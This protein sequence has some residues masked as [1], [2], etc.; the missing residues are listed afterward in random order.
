[1][2]DEIGVEVLCAAMGTPYEI[3]GAMHLQKPAVMR[4]WHSGVRGLAGSVTA[5]RL[6]G[7]PASIAARVEKLKHNLRAYGDIHVFDTEA[8]L[9]FWAE[10]RQLT[11]FYGSSAALWRISTT[12]TL[13]PKVVA[14]IERYMKVEAFYDWSG[15]LIW[16]EVPEAADAGATDIRR[17]I[18]LHGGHATLIRAEPS[19]RA[20]V[21][22]FQP[23]EP[24][25]ARITAKLKET[26]DPAGVFNPGRMYA[27]L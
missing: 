20:A 16:L 11:V 17:I 14:G 9:G 18:A 25:V 4:L 27:N 22:V 23:L 1:L 8:S 10:M 26:F 24:G 13:G 2:P 6:E 3:T 12:P 15:G 19:V 7:F 5:L 21:E